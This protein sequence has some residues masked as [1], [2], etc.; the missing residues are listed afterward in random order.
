MQRSGDLQGAYE[1]WLSIRAQWPTLAYPYANLIACS[2]NLGLLQECSDIVDEGLRRFPA[3]IGI[4]A[5]AA[6][7][8]E[9]RGR[10]EAGLAHWEGVVH[11]PRANIVWRQNYVHNL[12][13]L[14]R[15][16]EANRRLDSWLP[17]DP[18]NIGF[19]ALQ[20]MIASADKEPD[21][22]LSLWGAYRR[23]FPDDPV[24]W[25]HY[26]RAFQAWQLA[27]VDGDRAA[28]IEAIVPERIERQD[29]DAKRTLLLSFESI[30]HNCEFG[31]VQRRFGAE[32]LGLLRFNTVLYG[33]LVSA[34]VNGFARMGDP[35]VTELITTGNGEYF[36]QDRRWGLG[37]HTFIFREQETADT[38]YPRLCRRVAFLRDKF[39]ADV[40][41][42]HKVLVFTCP[43]I[44]RDDLVMLHRALRVLGPV[45]L[46]HVVSGDSGG[47]DIGRSDPGTVESLGDGLFVAYLSRSGVDARSNWDIPFDEWIDICDRVRQMLTLPIATSLEEAHD[48][49]VS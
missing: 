33:D 47:E 22:A 37:M 38:L 40:A 13:I 26:G 19:L 4:K 11:D 1:G 46:L 20:A 23:R 34:V 17:R 3:D 10:W 8:E 12:L 39:L 15:L 35:E 21:V 42:G 18:D 30:G 9:R 7:F 41:E 43:A 45:T 27:T 16:D 32:P 44:S 48:R 29:D 14:G 24:G 28:A 31:L 2:L 49:V 5:E 25:E 36:V 6:R